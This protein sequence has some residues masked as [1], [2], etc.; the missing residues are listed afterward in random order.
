MLDAMCRAAGLRTGL[1]T[2]PHLVSVRERFR[3]NGECIPEAELLD[4][5]NRVRRLVDGWET[6]PTFF[7]IVTVVALDWFQRRG[8]EIVV[9]ETGLGGRLDATNIVTPSVCVLTSVGLDHQQYLGAT[10]G[11]IAEEKAGIFKA[12]VPVVSAPQEAEVLEVFERR[13]VELGCVL[14]VGQQPWNGHKL[15]LQGAVQR[16]NAALAE[17]ALTAAQIPVDAE[18]RAAGLA[19]VQWAGRFQEVLPGLVLDGAHNPAAAS[20]LVETWREIFGAV[21]ATVIFASMQDKDTD[22]VLR[23]L[24]PIVGDMVVVP[25]RNPR[26]LGVEALSALARARVKGVRCRESGSVAEAL[27]LPSPGPRLVTGSLFLVGEALAHLE[28]GR[29]EA[30]AQ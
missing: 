19:R 6:H 2:S 28:G 30:T 20:A 18:A 29:A 15:G 26:A 9:L 12:G 3:F 7:E 10:L 13:A 27:A 22:A 21:R 25:V 23:I 24:A 1:Y 8:A 17:A 14:G 4:A 11:E 5:L 16:W